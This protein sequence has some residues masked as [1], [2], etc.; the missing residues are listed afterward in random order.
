M[1]R[2]KINCRPMDPKHMEGRQV[3]LNVEKVDVEKGEILCTLVA[4]SGD[5]KDGA[6]PVTPIS[7]EWG[8]T[9]PYYEPQSDMYQEVMGMIEA[10]EQDAYGSHNIRQKRNRKG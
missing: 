9:K 10:L 5:I 7:A 1:P 2:I 8:P 4:V 3:I 6:I